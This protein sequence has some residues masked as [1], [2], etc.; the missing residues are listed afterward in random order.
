MAGKRPERT[1]KA[2]K[3]QVNVWKNTGGKFESLAFQ[4]SKNYKTAGEN[5][6]WKTTNNYTVQDLADL[7]ILIA[8][9]QQDYR[10]K[11][12]TPESQ[13]SGGEQSY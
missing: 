6:E 5:G 1:Y 12:Q 13:H 2:G 9:I 4:V 10:V 11:I 3:V 8:Q 7:A